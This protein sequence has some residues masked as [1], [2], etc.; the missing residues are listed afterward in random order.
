M[1]VTFTN[2]E[3]AVSEFVSP[4]ERNYERRRA[5]AGIRLAKYHSLYVRNISARSVVYVL[6]AISFKTY[7]LY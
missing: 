5:P 7:L 3:M 1:V 4:V 2:D 6:R